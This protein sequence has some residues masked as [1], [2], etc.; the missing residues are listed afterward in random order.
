MAYSTILY[1]KQRQGVL[2]TLNRPEQMNALS[3]ELRD[4]LHQAFDEAAADP[5]VRAI[6]L[7]GA[8]RALSAGAAMG[9]GDAAA[10]PWPS[11][12]AEGTQRAALLPRWRA[13]G[14]LGQRAR[15]DE[16]AVA[17]PGSGG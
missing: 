10:P 5:E 4:E 7:T 13:G 16:L 1:E 8:G 12:P 11:G 3:A 14:P 9:G 6:V 2:I 17:S 15:P